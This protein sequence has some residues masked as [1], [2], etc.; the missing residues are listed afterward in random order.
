MKAAD[1]RLAAPD[2]PDGF[3]HAT[4]QQASMAAANL[5][6]VPIHAQ[7]TGIACCA[8]TQELT[9]PLTEPEAD[10]TVSS[11]PGSSRPVITV[12]PCDTR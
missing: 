2:V 5:G 8:A 6:A 7:R 3:R 1:L 12:E 11:S 10:L 4:Q 9:E